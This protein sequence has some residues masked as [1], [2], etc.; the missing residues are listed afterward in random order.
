MVLFTILKGLACFQSEYVKIHTYSG[1]L[2]LIFQMVR[3][4]IC[5]NEYATKT[6]RTFFS[7]W[8][9]QCKLNIALVNTQTK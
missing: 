6:S 7:L 3:T 2:D 4:F 9:D 8:R 5:E 1:K